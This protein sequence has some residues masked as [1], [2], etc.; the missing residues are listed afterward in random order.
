MGSAVERAVAGAVAT[1]EGSRAAAVRMEV[2]AATRAEAAMGWVVV[3]QRA[4]AAMAVD[5]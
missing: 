2:A 4:A 5:F 1:P 3:E